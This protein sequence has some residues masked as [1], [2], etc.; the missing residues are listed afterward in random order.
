MCGVVHILLNLMVQN[1]LDEIR[2]VEENVRES[3]IYFKMVPAR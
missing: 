2:G 3:V 1:G